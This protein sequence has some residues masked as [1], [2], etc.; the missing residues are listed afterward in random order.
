M[1]VETR[2]VGTYSGHHIDEARLHRYERNAIGRQ[3]YVTYQGS[4]FRQPQEHS[5]RN[6][7]RVVVQKRRQHR[8]QSEAYDEDGEQNRAELLEE[9]VTRNVPDDV[10]Q[11]VLPLQSWLAV[12]WGWRRS[13]RRCRRW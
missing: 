5:T 11:F 13:S 3:E 1:G 4:A 7:P 2:E 10:L 9:E 12:N 6:Q 8:D